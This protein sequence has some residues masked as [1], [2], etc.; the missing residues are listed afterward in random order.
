M[1]R[2]SLLKAIAGVRQWFEGELSYQD[3]R[4][5]GGLRPEGDTLALSPDRTVEEVAN[6][7]IRSGAL[8]P[9]ANTK[10]RVFSELC[11]RGASTPEIASQP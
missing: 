1:I 10:R 5:F 4:H 2:L 11:G 9:S 6:H 8:S 3:S 7:V